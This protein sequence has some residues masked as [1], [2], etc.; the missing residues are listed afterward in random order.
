MGVALDSHCASVSDLCCLEQT[1]TKETAK[2]MTEKDERIGDRGGGKSG[3]KD[4][5]KGKE[6]QEN[7]IF[8]Q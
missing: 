6:E 7:E 5:R 3:Y 8:L 4:R 2:N 1:H